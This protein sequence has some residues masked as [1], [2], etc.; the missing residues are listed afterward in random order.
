MKAID[1]KN[2]L[3]QMYNYEKDITLLFWPQ[4]GILQSITYSSKT[5]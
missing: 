1:L 3:K 2:L 5:V 4:M